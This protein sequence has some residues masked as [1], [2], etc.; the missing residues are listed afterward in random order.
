M[1][2]SCIS[3]SI[4]FSLFAINTAHASFHLWDINEVYSNADG[5]VQFIELF[6]N[7]NGQEFVSGKNITSTGAADFTFPSN[8]PTSTGGHHLLLA[9]GPINGV[10]PDYTIPA[11][12]LTTGSGTVDFVGADSLSYASLPTNGFASLDGSANT[13]ASA[14]P[15]NFSGSTSTLASVTYTVNSANDVDDGTCDG[16]HCS[17]REAINAANANM[18]LDTIAFDITGTGP[19]SIAPTSPLPTITDPVIIDGATEPDFAGT[20]VIELNGS[21][22]G[23]SANG[24]H[25]TAGG[26]TLR[27]LAVNRFGIDGIVLATNGDNL[28]EGC[29]IGTSADGLS[30]LGNAA[31]GVFINQSAGNT[32]GGVTAAARNIISGNDDDGID[33]DGSGSTNNVVMGN[34][35]G[36]DVNCVTGVG[37]FDDGI[38]IG[39]G[40]S[41]NT[42]GGSGMG[43]GNVIS[44]NS[45]DGIDLFGS[46][47][48]G[49]MIL[50]NYIGTDATGTVVLGNSS[51]GVE[52]GGA[53]NNTIGGSTAGARNIISGNTDDG[54]DIEESGATG[55]MVLGNYIGTDATGAVKLGNTS[56]GIEIG[57]GASNN[58][59]GGSGTGEGNVISG[60]ALEGILISDSGTTGNTVLGNFIGTDATGA[61]ALGNSMDGI[62]IEVNASNN[63]I[64]GTAAGARNIISANGDDG[65]DID[66]GANGNMVLGNF[67]GTD[68]TGTI[69][70]GNFS[71]GVEIDQSATGNTVGGTA[72]GAR[73]I[74]SGNDSQGISFEN[75]STTGNTVL[76]NYIG[77]DVNGTADLGNSSHGIDIKSGAS[78]NT[79]GGASAGAGNVISGNSGEGILIIDS[80]T[81]GN[82]VLGN[83]IGTDATGVAPL[84][85]SSDGIEIE[86]NAS[87]NTVGGTDPG[88]RNVISANGDDGVDIDEG[89][90]GNMVLGNYI[91]TDATGASALGNISEGVE[92]DNAGFNNT[93]G[94]TA[95]GAGNVISG[96]GDAGIEFFGV[97]TTGNMVLGNFIGTDKDGIA[98]LGNSFEG[99]IISVGATDNMIGG[100][101]VGDGNVIAGNNREGVEINDLGTVGN[102]VLG[103]SIFSNGL[104][105]IDLGGD[106]ANANDTGDH[107]TGPNN[108][109]NSPKI[110]SATIDVNDDLLIQY[111]VESDP[112]QSA[113]P[114]TIEFFESDAS[115]EGQLFLGRDTYNTT[116]FT[117]GV[118]SINLGNVFSIMGAGD[119]INAV[120]AT[121]TDNNGNTS[122]FSSIDTDGDGM[123]NAWEEF[124]GLN[125]ND[126]NDGPT[127]PDGDPFS[128]LLEFLSST[129][130]FDPGSSLR[131]TDIVFVVQ[132]FSISFTTSLSRRYLVE[133]TNDLVA[134]V[135]LTLETDILGTGGIVQVTDTGIS[136]QPTRIYRVRVLD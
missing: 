49:N 110:I 107:D 115:G 81:S 134:G 53:P 136:S 56:N 40:A 36:I 42:I 89:A 7:S 75:S 19:H 87:N 120:V 30:D 66:E 31:D 37:N 82:I 116:D 131:I 16:T 111:S 21:G 58:M 45:D 95:A 127:N 20:P 50:G 44:G 17:L 106:N 132:D 47:T 124:W 117:N 92:I 118:K 96:N 69:D 63:T 133:Y 48:T 4:C 13:V 71:D 104:L 93:I 67:I 32:I 10:T 29:F 84:G 70:L 59:I 55:N 27:S 79:I 105:G 39:D 78:N 90:N 135:W 94:G 28:I 57:I 125:F 85:N 97:G 98:G 108:L 5:S 2:K 88:A 52:I 77:T 80:G 6:T 23:V 61:A 11:N 122:E 41:N 65:I 76:G 26:S 43:E 112:T 24:L 102:T 126:L 101:S 74:I 9:T 15:T 3:L 128:N 54:I 12:F 34:Y 72:S 121:A 33:F 22:A 113:Y 123:P 73:N 99:I 130:P 51:D 64:G 83:F 25:I 86:V 8:S 103:N 100:T 38:E 1:N 129:D 60:N 109:Q 62:E 18:G 114:L 46:G 91:G 119:K 35:I 14:T 68:A